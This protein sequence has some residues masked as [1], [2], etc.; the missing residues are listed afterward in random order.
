ML[1]P[2]NCWTFAQVRQLLYNRYG[3]IIDLFKV[4]STPYGGLVKV[5]F[6]GYQLIGV[7]F[8]APPEQHLERSLRWKLIF[9]VQ[10]NNDGCCE[11]LCFRGHVGHLTEIENRHS[12]SKGFKLKCSSAKLHEH[13]GGDSHGFDAWL[14][15]ELGLN[16]VDESQR[17]EE[18][19]LSKYNT[20]LNELSIEC[21]SL[22]LP[23]FHKGAF[24]QPGV[25]KGNYSAHGNEIVL[26][27]YCN[28]TNSASITKITGD[29]NV[30]AE[31]ESIH[32]Y[33]SRPLFFTLD[34]QLTLTVHSYMLLVK[35]LDMRS[36]PDHTSEHHHHE[37]Q[38]PHHISA[39]GQN[40]PS[41]C[42]ARFCSTGLIAGTGF[43][44][45]Q[46]VPGNFIVFDD[47]TFAHLWLSLGNLAMFKRVG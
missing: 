18:L 2:V 39:T 33:L 28:E 25:F 16:A 17:T 37:F 29:P 8:F 12:L 27:T 23:Y 30:P 35:D 5:K 20:V 38:L 32:V 11:C 7:R 26:L 24:I 14:C 22:D 21:L 13:P 45:S 34:Q 6:D 15:D 41:V 4:V 40:V 9:V 36:A 19:T 44:H 1:E 42:R 31:K 3:Q 47:D 10:V 43:V 46:K